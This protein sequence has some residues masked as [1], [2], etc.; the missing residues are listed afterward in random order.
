MPR[1][2]QKAR[3]AAM[4]STGRQRRK[5][6]RQAAQHT[7]NSIGIVASEVSLLQNQCAFDE[8]EHRGNHVIMRLFVAVK[9][10]PVSLPSAALSATHSLRRH[11]FP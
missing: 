5:R 9:P 10:C 4:T 6:D 8:K 7:V 3:A 11:D 1:P 2:K